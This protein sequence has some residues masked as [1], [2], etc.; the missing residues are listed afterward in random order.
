MLEI[1]TTQLHKMCYGRTEGFQQADGKM[2]MAKQLLPCQLIVESEAAE[3]AY[4]EVT[5]IGIEKYLDRGI[6]LHT[7][8]ARSQ[9]VQ[10][11]PDLGCYAFSSC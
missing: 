9:D 2:Q 11:Q 7:S 8:S 6:I 1:A 3:W 4:P 10:L 5:L